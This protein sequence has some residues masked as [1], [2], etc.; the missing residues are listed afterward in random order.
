M[1]KQH[2]MMI[3]TSRQGPPGPGKVMLRIFSLHSIHIGNFLKSLKYQA[4]ITGLLFLR[5]RS[6]RAAVNKCVDF[7][8]L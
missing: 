6:K 5:G 8:E 3:Q 2:E 1:G 4:D 7:S